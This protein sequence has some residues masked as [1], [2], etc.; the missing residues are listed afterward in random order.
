MLGLAIL[1]SK[2]KTPIKL[3]IKNHS[4]EIGSYMNNIQHG[5]LCKVV[6]K[7]N[8]THFLA[9][10]THYVMNE[11]IRYDIE[12]MKKNKSTYLYLLQKPMGAGDVEDSVLVHT[13]QVRESMEQD[14]LTFEGQL[15]DFDPK[16]HDPGEYTQLH[17]MTMVTNEVRGLL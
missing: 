9:G 4:L 10:H 3:I 13:N 15:C 17:A 2:Y 6:E 12:M 14:A 16:G 11:N 8:L 7:G 5:L 1:C